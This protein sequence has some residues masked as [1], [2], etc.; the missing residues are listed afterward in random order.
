M[1]PHIQGDCIFYRSQSLSFSCEA[2]CPADTIQTQAEHPELAKH[3]KAIPTHTHIYRED[4]L[5]L[6]IKLKCPCW[7]S[8]FLSLSF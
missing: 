7:I 4:E 1:R 5:L 2:I 8:L 6:L 3:P